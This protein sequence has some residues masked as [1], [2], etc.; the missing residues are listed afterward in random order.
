[1]CVCVGVRKRE[2]ETET[3]QG[4]SSHPEAPP[5]LVQSFLFLLLHR[6]ES[7]RLTSES[8]NPSIWQPSVSPEQSRFSVATMQSSSI[9]FLDGLVLAFRQL[10]L[11][12]LSLFR[13]MY[14]K[15]TMFVQMLV[16]LHSMVLL[17]VSF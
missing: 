12:V 3:Q 17:T 8:N 14:C 2:F 11:S 7:H 15:A 6:E 10:T 4:V 5:S 9:Y 1:V 13:H 16:I